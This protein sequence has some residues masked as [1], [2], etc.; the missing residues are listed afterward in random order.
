MPR[1][2]EIPKKKITQKDLI[3][4]QDQSIIDTNIF[5]D[6]IL[7]S[8]SKYTGLNK[9]EIEK[10]IASNIPMQRVGEAEDL[11]GLITFLASQKADYMPGLAV[12]VVGGSAR[13]FT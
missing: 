6:F 2:R 13:P 4:L 7:K 1:K 3:G 8:Q 9:E 5:T 11:A 10:N 12:Q